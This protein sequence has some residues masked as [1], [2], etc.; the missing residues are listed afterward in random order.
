MISNKAC[1]IAFSVL[2]IS[3]VKH[4]TVCT[5]VTFQLDCSLVSLL[6]FQRRKFLLFFIHLLSII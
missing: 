1:F 6:A 3:V 4:L 2:H 5:D